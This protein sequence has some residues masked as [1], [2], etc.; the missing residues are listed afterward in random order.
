[1][2]SIVKILLTAIAVVVLAKIMPGVEVESY[3]VAILVAIVLALLRLIVKP[4]LILFTL[5]ITILTFG[6][7]LLFINAFIVMM[8]PYVVSGFAVSS[9]WI[10]MLFSLLLAIFESVLFSVIKED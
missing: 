10:A 1:M 8:V 3:G 5:P 2:K 7:F 4:L 6:L 9:V